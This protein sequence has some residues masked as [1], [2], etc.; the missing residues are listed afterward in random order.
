[1]FP[2]KADNVIVYLSADLWDTINFFAQFL[3]VSFA[4]IF[5]LLTILILIVIFKN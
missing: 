3:T 4:I 2:D 1:M 5:G